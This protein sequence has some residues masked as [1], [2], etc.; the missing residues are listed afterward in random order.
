MPEPSDAPEALNPPPGHAPTVG[1]LRALTDADGAT[2]ADYARCRRRGLVTAGHLPT[3]A[4][5]AM[6]RR[7]LAQ[8]QGAWS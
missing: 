1:M 2:E 5:R 3:K 7:A 8:R 4:G 6:I